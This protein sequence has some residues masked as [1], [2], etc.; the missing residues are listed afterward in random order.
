MRILFVHRDFPGPYRHLAPALAERGHDVAAFTLS[1][2]TSGAPGIEM[3]HYIASH[4]DVAGTR[5]ETVHLHAR[6]LRGD[7]SATAAAS[8]LADGFVPDVVYTHPDWGE[9]PFLRDVW[10]DASVINAC[11]QYGNGDDSCLPDAR[12]RAGNTRNLLSLEAADAG[13]S[14][15]RW[16]RSMFPER[17]QARISVIH[18]GIDTAL[19]RP[20]PGVRLH[21]PQ[22]RSSLA[23][24][25]E[26]ITVVRTGMGPADADTTAL[27]TRAVAELHRLRKGLHVVIA[28]GS[29]SG[30]SACYTGAPACREAPWTAAACG[31]DASR[32]HILDTL[33]ESSLMRLFQISSACVF[34]ENPAMLPTSLLQAMSCRSLVVA[35]RT[36]PVEE[37]LT[38]GRNG[39][40]VDLFDRNALVRVLASA[41]ASPDMYSGLRLRA[42]ELIVRRHDLRTVC[43]P[44]HIALIESLKAGRPFRGKAHL[45]GVPE[46]E[47]ARQ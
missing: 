14:S 23:A 30:A 34:P 29:E 18:D 10:P 42:R 44:A 19:F 3:L 45:P 31:I 20:D 27:L 43:V 46:R 17:S 36:P 39:I 5:P 35:L 33:T 12:T 37:V 26:I 41:V 1:P 8:M 16:Q 13:I 2:Q 21:L 11:E 47:L 38:H 7:R 32:L 6:L 22:F 15:T 9:S 40:L 24:G 4:G 25:Q 28:N